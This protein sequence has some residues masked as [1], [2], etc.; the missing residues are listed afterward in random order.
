MRKPRGWLSRTFLVVV[1]LLGIAITFR[2]GWI[3]AR[4]T[5]LPALDID[6]PLPL[7]I[8]W[9]L[10]ELKHDRELCRRVVQAS[11]SLKAR[12]IAPRINKNG[13][14]WT[15]A[16]RMSEIGGAKIGVSRVSCEVAAALALWSKFEVQ[17]LAQRIFGQK[18]THIQNFG[19]YSC[20][21]II[22]SKFWR[23][24]LSEHAR[25]NAIDISAFRLADGTRIVLKRDWKDTGKKAQFLRAIHSGACN[26]FRVS[27][28][29]DFNRAHH[30]H[31]HFDRGDLW[32]CR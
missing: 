31:F 27:L 30:D 22:G 16:V 3:P 15:N 18:V 19:T 7:M 28:G 1:A 11:K 4:Y 2:Q 14:G 6:S 21:K 8:D 13:C 29:P 23:N 26:Y 10:A 32:T 9:Q 12:P 25:A 17:P 5:P 24:R 20:R